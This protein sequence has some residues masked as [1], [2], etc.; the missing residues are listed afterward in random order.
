MTKMFSGFLR[1]S[2][3]KN[4]HFTTFLKTMTILSY[5]ITNIGL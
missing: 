1:D 5:N 3:P 4:S 2:L